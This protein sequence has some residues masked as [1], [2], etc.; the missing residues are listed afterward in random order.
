MVSLASI[1]PALTVIP[2][3]PLPITFKNST[4][5]QGVS[6]PHVWLTVIVGVLMGKSYEAP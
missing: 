4:V 2:E 5:S 3:A 6:V 1:C